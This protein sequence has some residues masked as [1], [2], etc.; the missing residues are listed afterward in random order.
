MKYQMTANQLLVIAFNKKIAGIEK[1][2]LDHDKYVTTQEIN[3]LTIE[4]FALRLRKSKFS[5][6]KRY[7]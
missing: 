2:I 4:K 3:K 5:Q 7:F 6:Q 1:K